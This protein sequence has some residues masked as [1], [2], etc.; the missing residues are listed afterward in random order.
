MLKVL[1]NMKFCN[2]FHSPWSWLFRF[3]PVALPFKNCTSEKVTYIRKMWFLLLVPE[4]VFRRA[5][6]QCCVVECG[7]SITQ[8]SFYAH[9]F[10][11]VASVECCLFSHSAFYP[12]QSD[13]A[14]VI[15][16]WLRNSHCTATYSKTFVKC[17]VVCCLS[18][19]YWLLPCVL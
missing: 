1:L 17:S 8:V 15:L 9:Y 3:T 7:H 4:W 12:P 19:N 13:F 2:F 5:V 6:N 10:M 11:Y 18:W 14:H 16:S